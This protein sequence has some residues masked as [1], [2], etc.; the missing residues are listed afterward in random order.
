[1]GKRN[2]EGAFAITAAGDMQ[3]AGGGLLDR[4]YFL[5]GVAG[6]GAL[7]L[8]AN[9]NAKP[10]TVPAW[11]SSPGAPLSPYGQP[12]AHE[13]NVQRSVMGLFPEGIGDG[14]GISFTPL[15]RLQGTITPNGLFFERHHS[16]VPDIDP[17]QHRLVIHGQVRQPRSFSVE[18]LF[19]LPMTTYI[20]FLECAGNSL[21]NSFPEAQKRTAGEIHG[22]VSCTEW[23]G[24]R[25]SHLLEMVGVDESAEW[26]L[27]EGADAA[28]QSRSVPISKAI[29][30]DA[31]I[32]LYQNGERLRPQQGYPM[33]LVLPGWQG[34]MQTKW[35]RRIKVGTT[36]T[37][38]KDET[39]Q[40]TLLQKDGRARQF[41]YAMGVKSVITAPSPGVGLRGKGVYQI[42]GLAWSGQGAVKRV[43][44][45][46][47]GGKSWSEAEITAQDN[48]MALARFT[49]PW[50]WDGRPT[51]L[52]SRATDRAGHVQPTRSVWYEPYAAGQI[53]HN[54]AIQSWMISK[55]GEVVNVYV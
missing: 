54:N 51:I 36:P 17:A 46:A 9:A 27:T 1:M 43:D 15:E 26:L 6:G 52:M 7:G 11:T 45:S 30:G 14:A 33:R 42:S 37:Y 40:Y 34:S 28:K 25:L 10:L 8:M 55:N 24:V 2:K 31:L 35:L 53:F 50:R 19:R 16:G 4:R 29:D 13:G 18:D 12:S 23:T 3:A 38:T 5:S 22:L 49:A 20:A 48:P 21:F 44:I 39:S 41:T 47:D 32:A